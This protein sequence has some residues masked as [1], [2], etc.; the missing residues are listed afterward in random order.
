[1][2]VARDKPGSQSDVGELGEIGFWMSC[3]VDGA[4][5]KT[6]LAQVAV[7]QSEDDEGLNK[8][9]R[10]PSGGKWLKPP[11]IVVYVQTE[12]L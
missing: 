7:V 6:C 11:D 3:R 5:G 9:L 8:H 10:C 4:Q 2:R 1:M 12:G